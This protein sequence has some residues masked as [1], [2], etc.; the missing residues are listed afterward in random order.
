MDTRRATEALA[1]GVGSEI[2]FTFPCPCQSNACP[3][4]FS[5]LPFLLP[6]LSFFFAAFSAFCLQSPQIC[7]VSGRERLLKGA[8]VP[9]LLNVRSTASFSVFFFLQFVYTLCFNG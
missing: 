4:L 5:P 1:V 3:F 9:Q 6:V 8:C 7:S 2:G